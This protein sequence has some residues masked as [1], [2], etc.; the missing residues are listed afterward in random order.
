MS[1]ADVEQLRT[2]TDGSSAFDRRSMRWTANEFG[3]R[4]AR[5]VSH[6]LK[7]LFN[8][9]KRGLPRRASSQRDYS[10]KLCRRIEAGGLFSVD[11]TDKM[12]EKAWHGDMGF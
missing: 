10:R 6:G 4:G 1:C 7:A 3:K 2:T 8:P 11:G 5:G 12:R 9:L